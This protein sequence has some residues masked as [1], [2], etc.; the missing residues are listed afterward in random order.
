[1]FILFALLKDNKRMMNHILLAMLLI[2]V[3]VIGRCGQCG[4]NLSRF[5]RTQYEIRWTDGTVTKT[6]GVQCGLTQQILHSEKF[7]S[8]VAKDYFTGN[9]FDAK[10]GFYVFGS[11]AVT[12][13]AP[14]FIA[15][16]LRSDAE[17]FQKESGGQVLSFDEALSLWAER[18]ARH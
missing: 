1:L 6:C 9:A 4:M 5:N 11:K 14:G 10:T 12:D 16:R 15:F 18:K 8:S 2:S 7:K 3:Q 13:M 17:K